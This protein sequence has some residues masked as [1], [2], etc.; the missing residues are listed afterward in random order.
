M[1]EPAE[2]TTHGPRPHWFA[3][4]PGTVLLYRVNR[5]PLPRPTLGGG[6]P[7]SWDVLAQG[8]K[9]SSAHPSDLLVCRLAAADLRANSGYRVRRRTT[10]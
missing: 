10:R 4:R 1:S 2:S 8:M 6:E 5:R 9:L 3:E 7:C